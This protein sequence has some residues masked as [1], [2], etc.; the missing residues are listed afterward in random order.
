MNSLKTAGSKA[1][2]SAP[3]VLSKPVSA[4]QQRKD[5]EFRHLSEIKALREKTMAA[6]REEG[7]REGF[8]AAHEQGFAKGHEEGLVAGENDARE[9]TRLALE[10][11]RHLALGF[12]AALNSLDGNI[13]EQ[14]AQIALKIG[15]QLA[16]DAIK[17]SPESILGIVRSVLRSDPEMIGKPRLSANPEDIEMIKVAFGQ[18]LESLGW[19]LFGDSQISRGGCKVTSANG[20]IDATWE[21]RWA[22]I[23][24]EFQ[25]ESLEP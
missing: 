13:G 9:K 11:I 22:S 18:E 24:H 10:P 1:A 3:G 8:E 21:T 7:Y 25:R 23:E 6:A 15:Q 5:D 2:G 4:A 19:T 12:S 14:I 16:V 20:E 17:L